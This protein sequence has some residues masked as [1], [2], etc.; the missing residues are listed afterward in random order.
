MRLDDEALRYHAKGRKGKIEVV[1]TKELVTQRDLTLAYSPGVA[2]PCREIAKDPDLAY[3]YT[4][5]G[6]LVAVLTNGTAILGLGDIGGL[7]GKPVM[8]GKANL[9]KRFADI[10]AFDIEL[11][12]KTPEEVISVVRAIAPTFGGI[13]LEDIKAPDCFE[14]ER[15]LQDLGIPVFHDDQHGTAIIVCAA[16]INAC[17]VSGRDI[18]EVKMVFTGA[19]AAA[20]ATANM[21]VTLGLKTEN[22]YMFDIYGLIYKGRKEDMFPEKEKFAQLSNN[23]SLAEAL[24]DA[25][26]FIGLSAG[27]IIKPEMIMKMKPQPIIFA[28]ANP[29][30]EI[31]YDV[32]KKARPD[33]IMAT[34]RSDFPNQVNNVL[35]FPFIFRGALDCRASAVTEKMKEAAVRAIAALAKEPVPESVRLAYNTEDLSFGDEYLIPKPFDPRVLLW[36]APAIAKA[37]MESGVARR[38]IQDFDEYRKRLE[39]LMEKARVVIQPLIDRARRNPRRIV[40]TDG[41]D[42]KIL[43]TVHR[44]IDSRIC[45]PVLIGNR[46]RIIEKEKKI[47]NNYRDAHNY[48]KEIEIVDPVDM[49]DDP[50]IVEEYWKLRQRRGLTR[51]GARRGLMNETVAGSMLIHLGRAD[52][53]L[54]GISIPY[55]DTIRP[56]ISVLGNDQNSKVISGTYVVL[57]KG[58]RFFFGD[59]TVN[60]RPNAEELAQIAINTANVARTFGYEPRVAMLSFSNFGTHRRDPESKRIQNAIQLVREREPDLQIDGEMQADI[61]VSPELATEFSFSQIAGNA[62]VL[63]FPD[64]V[65]GNIAYKLLSH[66]GQATTIGPVITGIRRPI[67]AL[68]IGASEADVF[69][70]TAITVNQVLDLK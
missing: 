48:L 21:L 59:C 47:N 52:G 26:V 33:A 65:S 57:T 32:A 30:S 54:G 35:G 50:D 61:A 64:L 58:R 34:G 51:E 20:L 24:V 2:A 70:M 46:E 39:T 8:E 56:A 12:A 9:F 1:P 15:S 22:L 67:N 13:N 49:A 38:P 36:V 17:E 3:E 29:V 42:E 25:D 18:S 6:N 11:D 62:N 31:A 53:L 45:I 7:A 63:I 37:A 60:I 68:A 44:L 4:A 10:D 27:N 40:F 19:G 28:L 14:I 16:M 41:E 43:R 5:K 55:A 66:I 69:N 23:S